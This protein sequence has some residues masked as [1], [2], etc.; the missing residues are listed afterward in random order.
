MKPVY[1]YFLKSF[2]VATRPRYGTWESAKAELLLVPPLTVEFSPLSKLSRPPLTV[3]LPCGNEPP[4]ASFRNPPLTVDAE[5]LSTFPVPPLTEAANPLAVLLLPPLTL[6][7][8]PLTSLSWP[9]LTV[10]LK[11]LAVFLK[12][13]KTED[14]SPLA[15]FSCPPLTDDPS[16]PIALDEFLISFVSPASHYYV[17]NFH[18]RRASKAPKRMLD[19]NGSNACTF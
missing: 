10:T 19:S 2:E 15:V 18:P 17:W 9:P 4:L 7:T 5:P 12:P 6:A 14:W 13:P 3:A 1:R 16:S 8:S 11:P